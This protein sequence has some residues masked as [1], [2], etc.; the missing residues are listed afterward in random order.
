MFTSFCLD[1]YRLPNAPHRSY[2]DFKVGR[3][4]L[5]KHL[6]VRSQ[7]GVLSVDPIYAKQLL[8]MVPS[9]F[10]SGRT[11]LYVC[12]CCADLGCGALT[13]RI[14]ET[15][16]GIVWEDFGWEGPDGD[17]FSQSDYMSR[18]GPFLFDK[19]QY[20]LALIPY[21]SASASA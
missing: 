8:L 9:E 16:A 13:V 17:R 4:A 2:V 5:A 20:R 15:D 7:V 1:T 3:L 6:D 18:T 11:P 19:R 12:S 21:T 14:E 10:K